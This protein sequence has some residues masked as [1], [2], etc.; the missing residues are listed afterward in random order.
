MRTQQEGKELQALT[1]TSHASPV[2]D[3][4]TQ[5]S[6]MVAG[7]EGDQRCLQC[8]TAITG[9]PLGGRHSCPSPRENVEECRFACFAGIA[10]IPLDVLDELDHV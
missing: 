8:K 2:L 5:G 1:R 6:V 3:H 4:N 10:A 9:E 7:T